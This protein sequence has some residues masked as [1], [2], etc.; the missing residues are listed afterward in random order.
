MVKRWCLNSAFKPNS[1]EMM[2]RMK[3]IKDDC[4]DDK[5]I[6]FSFFLDTPDSQ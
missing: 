3:P 1:N 6:C 2:E 4:I 5:I